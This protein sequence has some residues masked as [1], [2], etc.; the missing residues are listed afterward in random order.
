MNLNKIDIADECFKQLTSSSLSRLM[1]YSVF[2]P[3]NR[4]VTLTVLPFSSFTETF[5]TAWTTNSWNIT[6]S[7]TIHGN[8]SQEPRNNKICN[9]FFLAHLVQK[10]LHKYSFN[11][12]TIEGHKMNNQQEKRRYPQRLVMPPDT[13]STEKFEL[14]KFDQFLNRSLHNSLWKSINPTKIV[15]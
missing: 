6:S 10:Q 4:T 13:V 8:E 1:T 15:K 9:D 2:G 7:N 11:W 14:S 5:N 3:Y 12:G